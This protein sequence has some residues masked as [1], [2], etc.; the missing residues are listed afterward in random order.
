MIPTV[1]I[2]EIASKRGNTNSQKWGDYEKGQN[3]KHEIVKERE[4]VK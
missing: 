1:V 4:N 3:G 2:G